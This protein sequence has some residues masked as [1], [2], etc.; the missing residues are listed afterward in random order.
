MFPPILRSGRWM[1]P[2]VSLSRS[3]RVRSQPECHA[4]NIETRQTTR[5]MERAMGIEPTG[6]ALPELEN[7]RVRASADAKCD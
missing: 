5:K 2:V 3:L 4:T 1:A 6:K 7:K